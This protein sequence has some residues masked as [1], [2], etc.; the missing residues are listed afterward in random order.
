MQASPATAT[1]PNNS[2][3]VLLALAMAALVAAAFAMLAGALTRRL[4]LSIEGERFHTKS[5]ADRT[6]GVV[7]RLTF[8]VAL[9]ALV[10][11]A[12]DFAGVDIAVGLRDEDLAKWAAR[13]GVRVLLLLLLAFA[14]NRFAG[15]VIRR[16]EHE[17]VE[18]GE[19]HGFE[20]RK[21][22]QTLGAAARRFVSALIWITAALVILR[23]LDVDITPVLTGAGI[24]GLAVGFGAQTLVKDMIAGVFIIAEDQVRVGDAAIVNGIEGAVEEINLRTIVLR[25]IEGVV[26]TIANGDIRTLANRSKDF[27]YSVI[28]LNI[29]YESD[30]DAVIEAVKAAADEVAKDPELASSILGPLEVFGI[31]EFAATHLRLR[32]RLKT[33]PLRQA[34]VGRELRRQI[35]KTL[36]AHGVKLLSLPVLTS[37]VR[38][39]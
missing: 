12:L 27:A 34:E 6:V 29:G 4:L 19:S 23:E 17:V 5:I 11:P 9:L 26:Y 18:T 16:A 20:R 1:L 33:L 39:P 2:L 36:D 30:T 31:D 13:T 10:F 28:S 32:F 38:L 8:A 37:T 24:L 3:E 21:R 25:D 22:A 7:R 14:A 35:K 15:S